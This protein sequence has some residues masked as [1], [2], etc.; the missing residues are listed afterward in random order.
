MDERF[1]ELEVAVKPLIDFLNKYYNPMCKAIVSEDH[2]EIVS[3]E[4]G[5]PLKVRD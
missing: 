1:E 2:V 5:L 4:L 3:N